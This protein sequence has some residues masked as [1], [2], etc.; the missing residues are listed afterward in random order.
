MIIIETKNLNYTYEASGSSGI[1]ALKNINIKINQGDFVAIMGNTGSGKST[2]VKI[3]NALLKPSSGKVYF[4]GIDI[5]A[6][7]KNCRLIKNKIGMVFQYP[8]HQLF[9]ESVYKDISFGPRN[10]GLSESEIKKTVLQ[11]CEILNIDR[12]LL[13]RSPFDL[14][15]GEKRRVAIAGVL[16]MKPEVLILDEPTAGLDSKNKLAMTNTLKKYHQEQNTSIIMVTHDI[17]QIAKIANKILILNCSEL[18]F[19]GDF[20]K[21]LDL[22]DK[23][24]NIGFALPEITQI[25]LDLNKNKNN[26]TNNIFDVETAVKE[27]HRYMLDIK[28]F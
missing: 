7:K 9:E 20:S 28:V 5:F 27:I 2:L 13:D 14:S 1:N 6:N 8:E 10:M 22:R 3:F 4:K 24:H 19:F 25:I 23:L 15:G 17:E 16:A 12:D 26:F 21:I 18:V 11:T